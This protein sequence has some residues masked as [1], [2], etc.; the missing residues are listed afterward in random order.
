MPRGECL[1]IDRSMSQNRTVTFSDNFL[2]T[3]P[4]VDFLIIITGRAK[5]FL[6]L[7]GYVHFREFDN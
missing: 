3:L 7:V 5:I 2:I 6:G 4:R 1:T